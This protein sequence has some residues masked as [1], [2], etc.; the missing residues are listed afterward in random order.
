MGV[1]RFQNPSYPLAMMRL[2][3]MD[4]FQVSR[5]SQEPLLRFQGPPHQDQ[6]LVALHVLQA[7]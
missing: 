5:D 3:S 4:Y 7:P 2:Q 6:H 1:H